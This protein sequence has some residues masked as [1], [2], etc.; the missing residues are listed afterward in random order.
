MKRLFYFF[1]IYAII[2]L[3]AFSNEEKQ[4]RSLPVNTAYEVSIEHPGPLTICRR[5][6][7][8]FSESLQNLYSLD[9]KSGKIINAY[10]LSD[11]GKSPI[12]VAALSCQKESLLLLLN[13]DKNVKIWEL[14]ETGTNLK[15]LREYILPN[16]S[17]ATD[18]F[19][20]DTDCWVLQGQLLKSSD[21]KKWEPITVPAPPQLKKINEDLKLDPFQDWQ[22]SLN[23]AQGAYVKGDINTKNQLALLDPF[24]SQVVVN[25][26]LKNKNSPWLKWGKFGA[27]EG[28]FLSPK[29]FQFIDES[30]LAIADTKLKAIFL[31]SLEG[32]YQGILTLASE[33]I[34]SPDYPMEIV[35]HDHRLFVAD[36]RG[37]KVIAVD[38][39][40]TKIQ[41]LNTPELAIRQNL[42]RR[43]EVLK[44]Q[45]SSLCL[46]CHD[47]T[48]SNQL[49]KFIK[50]KHH[51][52]LEC[53][54]CHDPHHVI[55][56]PHFLRETS[57]QLCQSCHKDYAQAK[58]NHA[59][60]GSKKGGQ[61]KDCHASHSNTGK[62]LLKPLPELCESCH[63]N[64]VFFH[65]S[66]V[67]ISILEK[68]KGVHLENGKFNCQTC[69]QTHINW[70][71]SHFIKEPK[72]VLNFCSSCHG[73]K[74]LRLFK[75]FHK[76]NKLKKDHK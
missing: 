3:P 32:T 49:Y 20:N 14:K 65:K 38:I 1:L 17:R 47:G 36:F 33:K 35:S 13:T 21:L 2:C 56:K 73:D 74:S 72:E 8:V 52:P 71:E 67:D 7:W 53:S 66:T 62:I 31:F 43:E 24:H 27:W 18:L 15:T 22:A 76:S 50:L 60:Q 69:H 40:K 68:A 5:N 34:F 26:D 23:L 39:L 64:K 11:Q 57:Q 30:T 46:N 19:C 44:D 28:S 54:Q 29:A 75:E 58:T 10:P 42:F 25:K 51:H 59:W 70:K 16:K 12:D 9:I 41:E 55:K 37:N 45:P 63:Q 4:L 48:I 61:C 6:L